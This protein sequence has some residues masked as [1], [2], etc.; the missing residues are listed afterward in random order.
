MPLAQFSLWSAALMN[1]G[2]HL[3]HA[4]VRPD[5]VDPGV[6]VDARLRGGSQTEDRGGEAGGDDAC[7]SELLHRSQLLSYL[8]L[9]FSNR[10]S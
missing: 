8:S 1:R 2:V 5:L 9:L 7:E 3:G 4:H 6:V 10:Y